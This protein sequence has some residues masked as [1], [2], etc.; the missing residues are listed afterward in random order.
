MTRDL[1]RGK[2]DFV[3]FMD[4]FRDLPIGGAGDSGK[5]SLCLHE[6]AKT[7]KRCRNSLRSDSVPSFSNA[8]TCA[9]RGDQIPESRRHVRKFSLNSKGS[10]QQEAI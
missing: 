10:I 6:T 7:G 3:N 9:P 2:R 4:V 5:V 8:V 1:K